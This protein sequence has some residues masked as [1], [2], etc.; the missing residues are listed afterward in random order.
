MPNIQSPENQP[1]P[2]EDLNLKEKQEETKTEQDHKFLTIEDINNFWNDLPDRE[3]FDQFVIREYGKNPELFFTNRHLEFYKDNPTTAFVIFKTLASSVNIGQEEYR[4]FFNNYPEHLESVKELMKENK[5]WLDLSYRKYIFPMAY[6][7]L[8]EADKNSADIILEDVIENSNQETFVLPKSKDESKLK[9]KNL[10]LDQVDKKDLA[11]KKLMHGFSDGLISQRGH[12]YS[13]EVED[14]NLL[15]QSELTKYTL[16]TKIIHNLKKLGEPITGLNS[17]DWLV[18]DEFKEMPEKDQQEIWQWIIASEH[19]GEL[20]SELDFGK[21]EGYDVTRGSYGVFKKVFD[22]FI[23]FDYRM[24]GVS[25]RQRIDR[26]AILDKKPDQR[27]YY[28]LDNKNLKS[29]NHEEVESEKNYLSRFKK[30]FNNLFNPPSPEEQKEKQKEASGLEKKVLDKMPG[31]FKKPTVKTDREYIDEKI[32]SYLPNSVEYFC[33]KQLAKCKTQKDKNI[34]FILEFWEKNANPIMKATIAEVLSDIDVNLSASKLMD[35]LRYKKDNEEDK[36]HITSLLYRLEFEQIG[37]SEKGVKYLEKMYDLGEH[38]NSDHFAQRLTAKGD[39]GI[40]DDKKVLQKYFNLGDLTSQEQVVKPKIYEF[41]YETLFREKEGETSEERQQREIY[42]Q[43][44]KENYFDFYDDNFFKETGVS[45]NNLDFKE[46]GWFLMYHKESGPEKRVE[47][48]DFVREF[49]EGG[50][51][52][53]LSLEYND[54]NGDKILEINKHLDREQVET[55]FLEYVIIQKIAEDMQ[56]EM[57]NSEFLANKKMDAETKN[58]LRE[59]IYDA[60]MFRATDILTTAHKI[61]MEGG[62][63]AEFYNGQEIK[64]NEIDEVIE[65]LEIYKDYL[66]KM[67]SFFTESGKYQFDFI[68]STKQGGLNIYNFTVDGKENG[69]QSFASLSLRGEGT[70]GHMDNF[71]YDGEARINFLFSREHISSY[72]KDKSRRE[73]TTFR[74]DR[75]CLN[76]DEAGDK[77]IS[78]DNTRQDGRLSLDFGS[79]YEDS[80]RE[81]NVLGRVISIGNFYTSEEREKKPEFYHNKE[82]FYKDLGDAQVFKEIVAS[83][84]EYIK[85]KYVK[86]A[87]DKMK[88]AA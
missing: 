55:I 70:N 53:F 40:F 36:E 1:S 60:F 23:N 39:I 8:S 67:K 3:A 49:G 2:V 68:N 30:S 62:A 25:H 75:E 83:V 85:S 21:Q 26:H 32:S 9:I 45:F 31:V 56:S 78:K 4:T 64:V 86:K 37:V 73:A 57:K 35:M 76:F 63:R 28:D 82:S 38:N 11:K 29:V 27:I 65:A 77:V 50:L 71:E 33:L 7:M 42:L 74:L 20:S 13:H 51:K 81:N 54:S 17:P 84:E 22:Q 6:K 12:I 48:M 52:S 69:E 59:N 5:N 10:L 47:L 79:I 88:E 34:D 18:P 66:E 87:K 61:A 72:I 24:K 16:R 44:F 41:V 46:Q 19:Y 43:E 14:K 80:G 15:E 58:K